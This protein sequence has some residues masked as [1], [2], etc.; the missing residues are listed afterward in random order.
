LKV[1]ADVLVL[2]GDIG[3]FTDKGK[4][5]KQFIKMC[6]NQFKHVIVVAG[7]HEYYGKIY[8]IGEVER[9]IEEIVG[10]YDNVHFLQRKAIVIEGV[11][12][13][14]CTLWS[15]PV[16]GQPLI[17]DFAQI[18]Y[19]GLALYKELFYADFKYLTTELGKIDRM[20]SNKTVV[21]THHLPSFQLIADRYAKHPCNSFF[22]TDLEQLVGL[23]DYWFCGHTHCGTQKE[24]TGCKCYV[25]PY[26][27]PSEGKLETG[28]DE[29]LIIT[30]PL[31]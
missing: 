18:K 29:E 12:F 25:N 27:Y 28:F 11:R 6:A 1:D 22:A 20:S 26:G 24:I 15:L 10:E 7:N 13:I 2:A 8:S 30:L 31:G 4:R 21:I 16:E 9:M 5:Y 19:M 23:A 3:G 14:G 17:N